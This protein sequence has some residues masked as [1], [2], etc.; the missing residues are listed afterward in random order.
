MN[1]SDKAVPTASADECRALYSVSYIS[2]SR[3]SPWD[4]DEELANIEKTSIHHNEQAGLT[5]KLIYRNGHFVQ[6]LEGP[7]PLVEETMDRIRDDHRHDN[8]KILSAH[9]IT[10]RMYADWQQMRLVTE[11]PELG[12]IDAVLGPLCLRAVQSANDAE[13]AA[14]LSALQNVPASDRCLLPTQGSS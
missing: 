13:A 10:R 12:D 14:L 11:G 7:R 4:L 8:I 9:P 1:E 6:R 3:I 5:G 2:R